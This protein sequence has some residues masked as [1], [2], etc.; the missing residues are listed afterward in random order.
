MKQM[1]INDLLDLG[2]EREEEAHEFYSFAA[3]QTS[4]KVIKNI[5]LELSKEELDHKALLLKF[6]HDPQLA[7]KLV[8]PQKDYKLAEKV[9]LP[10]LSNDMK[11]ADALALAMKKEQLAVEFYRNLAEDFKDEEARKLCLEIANM[12]LHHKQKLENAYTDVAYVEDF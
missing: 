3:Q 12:E 6:K 5:F 11:P 8:A 1:N 2:V 4:N 10:V 7:S 9:E